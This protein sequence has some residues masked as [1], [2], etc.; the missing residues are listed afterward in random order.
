MSHFTKLDKANIVDPD[1]FIKACK[2][3]G[4]DQVARDAKTKDYYNNEITA[5][6]VCKQMGGRY[7]LALTKSEEGNYYDCQADWWGIRKELPSECGNQGIKND[8][9]VQDAILRHTTKHTIIRKY[10]KMGF[11]AHVKEDENNNIQVKL[12]RA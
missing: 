12:Q 8:Q 2:E 1:A 9:D 11:S 10:K 5:D 7:D 4:F 6:V 3:L